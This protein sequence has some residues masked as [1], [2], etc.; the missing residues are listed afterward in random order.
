MDAE[1]WWGV[2]FLY[3]DEYDDVDLTPAQEKRAEDLCIA[4]TRVTVKQGL[5]TNFHIPIKVAKQIIK[6]LEE[7]QNPLR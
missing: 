2:T 7:N 1:S 5:L 6:V 3:K 4:A